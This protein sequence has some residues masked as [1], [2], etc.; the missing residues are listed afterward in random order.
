MGTSLNLTLLNGNDVRQH[1]TGKLNK[2]VVEDKNLK[3][4]YNR[5]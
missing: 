1:I 4:I 5:I 3:M 2:D